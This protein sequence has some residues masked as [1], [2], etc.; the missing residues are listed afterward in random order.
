MPTKQH[1]L[2]KNASFTRSRIQKL[3]N[4]KNRKIYAVK[5]ILTLPVK[6]FEELKAILLL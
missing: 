5:F 3:N 6:G 2:K 4:N 1:F